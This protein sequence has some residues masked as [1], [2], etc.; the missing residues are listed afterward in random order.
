MWGSGCQALFQLECKERKAWI[1]MSSQLGAPADPHFHVPAQDHHQGY[2]MVEG[3]LPTFQERK[4]LPKRN[5]IRLVQ[6]PT[7]P[8]KAQLLQLMMHLTRINLL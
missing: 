3:S 1:R 8:N 4:V 6:L 5:V 7:E 2:H